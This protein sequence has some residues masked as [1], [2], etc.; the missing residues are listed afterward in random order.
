MNKERISVGDFLQ[1][2]P[3]FTFDLEEYLISTTFVPLLQSQMKLFI[4]A[5]GEESVPRYTPGAMLKKIKGGVCQNVPAY[6]D[7]QS[8]DD[9]SNLPFIAK[10]DLRSSP[11]S[12]LSQDYERDRLWLKH[13]SGTT[14]PPIPIWYSP[15]FYFQLL[16]LSLRKVAARFGITKLGRNPFFCLS[17]SDIPAAKNSIIV[18]PTDEVGFILQVVV[19]TT[20]PETFARVFELLRV[21]RFECISTKPSLFELLVE[22]GANYGGTDEAP[23]FLVSGG[24]LLDEDLRQ[25]LTSMFR[26]PVINTYGMTEFNVIASECSSGQLHLDDHA[27]FAEVYEDSNRP[28][29]SHE[30]GELVLS[31]LE[32][33]AMPLLRYRTGD[34]GRISHETCTCGTHGRLLAGFYGRRIRCFVMNTGEKLSPTYFNDLFFHFPA[35]DEFQ[36]AQKEFDVFEVFVAFKP[37]ADDRA[38]TL[39]AIEAHVR[40]S[41]P[42]AVKL[43]AAEKDFRSVSKFER[44]LTLVQ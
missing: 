32:N 10:N 26:A 1:A 14:G 31:S 2:N 13:T 21:G 30:G 11:S 5:L 7:Y 38:K 6:R 37:D 29:G 8:F 20:R 25:Q 28:P 39:Q 36:I 3:D 35:L 19:D 43:T 42:V 23:L 16:L 22:H 4:A 34:Q 40:Q 17:I 33:L 18:D 9:Y 24:H 41:I 12:F 27:L 15:E 44:Y